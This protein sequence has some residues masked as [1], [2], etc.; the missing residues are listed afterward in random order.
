MKDLLII[1]LQLYCIMIPVS[2]IW[3]FIFHYL[4]KK[5][6][7]KGALSPKEME[8][9]DVSDFARYLFLILPPILMILV[10]IVDKIGGIGTILLLGIP[11][12]IISIIR[13]G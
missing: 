4:K 7:T 10:P 3:F 8:W 11:G 1:T 9:K 2:L 13:K 6:K 5:E 12:A